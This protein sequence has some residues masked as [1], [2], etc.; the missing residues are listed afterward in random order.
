MSGTRVRRE[1]S[2]ANLSTAFNLLGSSHEAGPCHPE[3][4]LGHPEVREDRCLSVSELPWQSGLQLGVLGRGREQSEVRE[5]C[6]LSDVG[7]ALAE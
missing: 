5:D 6:C 3:L 4:G 2:R 7:A 1:T